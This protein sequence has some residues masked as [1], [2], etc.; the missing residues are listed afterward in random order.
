MLH[1]FDGQNPFTKRQHLASIGQTGV[2]VSYYDTDTD[3]LALVDW[4]AAD[5]FTSKK[6]VVI[7]GAASGLLQNWD[8]HQSILEKSPYEVVLY[9]PAFERKI[10][11]KKQIKSLP[12][13]IWYECALPEMV[14]LS[15]W[16]I[17]YAHAN[18]I[19]LPKA[20]AESLVKL[21]VG[22][23]AGFGGPVVTGDTLHYLVSELQKLHAHSY[24][25]EIT[26][27][28]VSQLGTKNAELVVW[29]LVRA[30]EQKNKPRF[31][32]L[33]EQFL[34]QPDGIDEKGK[35]IQLASMIAEQLRAML[36]IKTARGDHSAIVAELGWKPSRIQMISRS[37]GN[38]S[39][40]GIKDVLQKLEQLDVEVKSGGLPAQTLF[41]LICTQA[42]S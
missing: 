16:L 30:F 17:S 26:T 1:I 3:E 28:L 11:L 37:A 40:Q 34:N 18:N 14:Q 22:E 41:A 13:V 10:N 20:S 12:F 31:F 21:L 33:F 4:L 15:S 19:A 36:L 24:N 8:S 27:Q 7:K 9:E 32:T 6:I 2:E 29:D 39:E 25:E 42:L 35:I 5:L 23:A 38:F